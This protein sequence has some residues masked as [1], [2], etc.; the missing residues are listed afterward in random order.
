MEAFDKDG[1]RVLDLFLAYTC[2]V[3]LDR[4]HWAIGEYQ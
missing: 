4:K 1:R 3:Y 2:D